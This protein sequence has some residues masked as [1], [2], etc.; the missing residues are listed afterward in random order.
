MVEIPDDDADDVTIATNKTTAATSA[1][2][3]GVEKLRSLKREVEFRNSLL[4]KTWSDL[5]KAMD[6]Y[7]AQLVEQHSQIEST[8][9]A[10]DQER[11]AKLETNLAQKTRQIETLQKQLTDTE[12][13]LMSKDGEIVRLRT[14]VQKLR[15]EVNMKDSLIAKLQSQMAKEALEYQTE[16]T[17]M[18]DLLEQNE[19]D[20]GHGGHGAQGGQGGH[21][22]MSQMNVKRRKVALPQRRQVRM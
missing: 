6:V 2:I 22:M 10:D 15:N 20:N 16:I 18:K 5:N 12:H 8:I 4:G 19:L 11:F 1:T 3:P 13:R 9:S 17:N 21:G 7:H 14:E